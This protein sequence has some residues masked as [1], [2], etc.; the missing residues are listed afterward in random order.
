M[1]LDWQREADRAQQCAD[2][3][4]QLMMIETDAVPFEQAEFF[5]MQATALFAPEGMRHLK[6]IPA[7]G[8]Q[9]PLHRSF[10]RSLQIARAVWIRDDKTR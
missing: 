5:L 8:G 2:V 1:F 3:F 4:H 9:Q 6:N 10:R 7:P